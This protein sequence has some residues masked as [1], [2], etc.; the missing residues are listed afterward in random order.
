M[1]RETINIYSQ[2]YLLLES[3]KHCLSIRFVF[4]LFWL[5]FSC[6]YGFN[7]VDIPC[8]GLLDEGFSCWHISHLTDDW[9]SLSYINHSL[10]PSVRPLKRLLKKPGNYQLIRKRESAVRWNYLDSGEAC[11]SICY[12]YKCSV[13]GHMCLIY[14]LVQPIEL[15]GVA[16]SVLYSTI[17]VS[18][19]LL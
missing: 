9:C 18:G 1:W 3:E 12:K 13:S 8:H 16:G 15:C 4:L 19:C 17:G 6:V 7:M 11:G 10:H 14:Y 5:T 2:F